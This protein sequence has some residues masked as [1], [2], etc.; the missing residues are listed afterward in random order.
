MTTTRSLPAALLWAAAVSTLLVVL[1][2]GVVGS[3]VSIGAAFAHDSDA[4]H[5]FHLHNALLLATAVTVA[6][7]VV[8][9]LASMLGVLVLRCSSDVRAWPSMWQG[10][11]GAGL[12]VTVGPA[13]ASVLVGV[14]SAIAS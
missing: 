2:C 7:A 14:V 4:F 3:L 13:L 11:A 10:I 1:V 12:A 6:A 9:S 5:S 8:I